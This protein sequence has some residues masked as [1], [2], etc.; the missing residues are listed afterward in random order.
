MH[1]R[2][3]LRFLGAAPIAGVAAVAAK[4]SRAGTVEWPEGITI[5]PRG[6][7]WFRVEA[8]FLKEIESRIDRR[9]AARDVRRARI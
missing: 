4:P 9:M 6:V 8:A 3:F 2:S 7:S 1:R 5:D